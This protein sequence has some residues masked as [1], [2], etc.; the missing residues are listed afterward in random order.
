MAAHV[1]RRQCMRARP[2]QVLLQGV[3]WQRPL[4]AQANEEQVQGLDCVDEKLADESLRVDWFD[5]DF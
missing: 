2:A 5:P 4:C 3:R 1:P